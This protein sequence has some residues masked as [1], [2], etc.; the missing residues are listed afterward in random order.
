[1]AQKKTVRLFIFYI[2]YYTQHNYTASIVS[3]A[4]HISEE[5]F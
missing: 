2:L 5:Y 3:D 1:M 4:S